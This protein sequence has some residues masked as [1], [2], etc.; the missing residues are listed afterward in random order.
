ME[1]PFFFIED[2]THSPIQSDLATLINYIAR[3][4]RNGRQTRTAHIV[5][6]P[7]PGQG[8]I[9]PLLQFAKSLASKGVKATIATTRYTVKSIHAAG[10]AVEG[11]SDGFDQGGFTQAQDEDAYLKSFKENGTR[12]LSQLVHKYQETSF[13]ITCIIYD[14]FFPWALDVARKHGI[15][16]A[17]F[18]TNS[19]VVCAIFCHIHNGTLALPVN[20]EDEEPLVL[21]GLPPLKACDVPGFIKEP[22]SYPAYLA[23]KLSQFSN[24]DKADF[25]FCNSFQELEGK[26]PKL[27]GP[28]VPSYYLDGRIEGDKGYGASLWKPLNDHCAKWLATRPPKSVAY[29]SFGSMV[30]LTSKQTEEIAYALMRGNT[31]FLWVVRDSE[32]HKLPSQFLEATEH[33]GLIVS[34]CNQLE[35]LANGAVGCFVTHCGWNS[36]VEGLSL[37]VPM[38]A[39]PQWSDQ[40]TDAKFIE[41]VWG[42]GVRCREDEFGVVRSEEVLF[43]LKEVLEGE[44]CEVIRR[45]ARKWRVL[46][47]RAVGEGGSSDKCINEFVTNLKIFKHK[48]EKEV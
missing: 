10:V 32:R 28:M 17:S 37:G 38:V 24:L 33:R 12:T 25:V 2:R 11:I 29:I 9:N 31:H 42:L 48:R 1:I 39:I 22:E 16:G 14:S 6:L 19:A 36:T 15:L 4:S 34:W 47:I 3:K 18:F 23:M 27:V 43:C 7:Y 46:A 44:K 30:K 41:E 20:V 8:H 21:A 5:V 40:M 13:P 45:N 35:V 26:V